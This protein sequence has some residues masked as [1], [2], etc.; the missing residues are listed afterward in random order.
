[1]EVSRQKMHFEGVF[2]AAVPESRV[3][4]LVTDP[5]EVAGCMPGLQRV[6]IKSSD[7]F[8]AVVR[9]G[10]SFIRGDFALRFRMIEKGPSGTKLAIHGAGL[11]SAVDMEI[12]LVISAG[13]S[14]GSSMRWQ[15]DASVS[16]KIASLGQRLIESQAE[17]II[18]EFFGCFRKKLEDT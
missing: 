15:A 16:G 18:R 7:E 4:A 14:G 12:V 13:K 5:E 2:D 10:V 11:G 8:E 1:M 3:Y 17:K 6:D 9:V